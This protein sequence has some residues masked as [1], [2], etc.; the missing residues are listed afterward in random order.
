MKQ[1][2]V[3][4]EKHIDR[5]IIIWKWKNCPKEREREREFY[6]RYINGID[7]KHDQPW[8]LKMTLPILCLRERNLSNTATA[9]S[10]FYLKRALSKK[11]KK[12]LSIKHLI[13][14]CQAGKITGAKWEGRERIFKIRH[15]TGLTCRSTAKTLLSRR[16]VHSVRREKERIGKRH[17]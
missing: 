4:Y 8:I 14:V 12:A 13:E 15:D 2:H 7:K 6:F 3:L 10:V 17:M 1:M 9:F 11:L 5:T 16:R